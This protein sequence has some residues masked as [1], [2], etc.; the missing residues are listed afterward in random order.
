MPRTINLEQ[1]P[2]TLIAEIREAWHL[3]RHVPATRTGEGRFWELIP[4]YFC[5]TGS[6]TLFWGK[7]V[8]EWK[9]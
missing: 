1:R 5:A 6:R 8:W 9:T 2:E 4:Q 3:W 7:H